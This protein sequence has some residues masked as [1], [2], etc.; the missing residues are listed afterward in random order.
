MPVSHERGWP[1]GRSRCRGKRFC[2]CYALKI[3]PQRGEG[4]RREEYNF[5]NKAP[6]TFDTRI[7]FTPVDATN[8]HFPSP[9]SGLASRYNRPNFIL[10][11]SP[12]PTEPKNQS[13]TRTKED[14]VLIFK[15]TVSLDRTVYH[16]RPESSNLND[17]SLAC[18]TM[19]SSNIVCWKI[20]IAFS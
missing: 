2:A 10:P 12:R 15:K 7:N 17:S 5:W 14:T 8:S 3:A 18:L 16:T 13:F 11:P 20:M 9:V 1:N 6:R 19:L 4:K